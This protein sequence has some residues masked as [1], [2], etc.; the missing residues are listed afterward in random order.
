[1]LLPDPST[2]GYPTLN[3]ECRLE[4]NPKFYDVPLIIAAVASVSTE[5]VINMTKI[6]FGLDLPP[7]K[8]RRELIAISSRKLSIS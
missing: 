6:R 5:A 1:M 4:G 2:I 3:F 8:N 7:G